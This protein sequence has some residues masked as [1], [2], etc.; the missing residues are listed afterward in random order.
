MD[1]L[2]I[3]KKRYSVRS[4]SDR[5][6]EG[7]KLD[8]ILQAAHIA[9]TAANLQPVHLIVVQKK[10]GLEKIG[11]GANIYGAPLA[12]IVCADHN[13]AWV[14]PFDKKKTSDIDASILTDHMMMEATELGLGSVWVCYFK[15]DVIR[16][17]FSLPDNLEPINILAIGYSNEAAADP[18]R[19]SQ[20]RIPIKELVSYEKM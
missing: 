5:K 4:Y 1:F 8:K 20:N 12:I 7:E 17:E 14:R 18:E 10:D 16:K 15:P 11:K 2:E 13:K 3:A 19:H 6:V 9:P